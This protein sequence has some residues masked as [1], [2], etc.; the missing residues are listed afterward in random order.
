MGLLGLDATKFM[1][2]DQQYKDNVVSIIQLCLLDSRNFEQAINMLQQ[3]AD[4]LKNTPAE[5]THYKTL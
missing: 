1:A 2:L 5:S 4:L 3:L